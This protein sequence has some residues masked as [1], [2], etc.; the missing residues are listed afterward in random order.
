MQSSLARHLLA[1]MAVSSPFFASAFQTQEVRTGVVTLP[2]APGGRST[3]LGGE[4]RNVD[5]VRDQF[6]LK[7]YGGRPVKVLFDER[8]QVFRDGVRI[9][10]LTLHPSEHA[11][12]E[13][14]LDG[15]AI[16]AREIHV[17]T[18]QPEGECRGR[19]VSF[20]VATGLLKVEVASSNE[21]ISLLVSSST[22]ITRSVQEISAAAPNVTE[23]VPGAIVE[24]RFVGGSRGPGVVNAIDLIATPGSSFDFRGRLSFLDVEQGRL[25]ITDAKGVKSHEIRF[26]AARFPVSR[27]LHEGS[28][29]M[30]TAV[31]DGSTYTASQLV[32]EP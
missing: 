2:P 1:I 28:G 15:T 32:S 30:V 12:V 31:F 17:Q 3:A 5:A 6:I 20:N 27:S 16:F 10:V 8:T 9:P 13:T 24:V 26:D 23:L 29:V 7:V 19:V 14:T 11:S 25:V 18:Q 21:A 4:I 22:A